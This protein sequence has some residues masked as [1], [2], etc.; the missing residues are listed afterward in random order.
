MSAPI[1]LV[2]T[3]SSQTMNRKEKRE[4]QK[5]ANRSKKPQR[6]PFKPK[7]NRPTLADAQGVFNHIEVMFDKLRTGYIDA[8]NGRPIMS[9]GQ[10]DWLEIA[11][12]ILGWV[13]L[14]D[15][16]AERF[17]YALDTVPLK[18]LAN[19]LN[20]D[21]MLTMDLIDKAHAAIDRCRAIYYQLDV[22]D[23]RDMVNE[24]SIRMEFER[25][26]L[27]NGKSTAVATPSE[28]T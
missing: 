24:Q 20:Y 11:P 22:G 14:W 2:S 1:S 19:K 16:I 25:L 23:V 8:A 6:Q 7:T 9:D 26:N 28:G 18:L 12:A 15:R 4:A 3:E 21:M 5:Y 13:E 10:G 27:M 17:N